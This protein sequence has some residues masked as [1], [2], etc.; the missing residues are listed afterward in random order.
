MKIKKFIALG[1]IHKTEKYLKLILPFIKD[2]KPDHFLLCGDTADFK[3]ISDYDRHER[4]VDGFAL[5]NKKVEKEIKWLNKLLDMF[6]KMLP[7]IIKDYMMGNH[8]ARY[9]KFSRYEQ[10]QLNEDDQ[11]LKNRLRLKERGWRHTE[12][13]GFVK[14]GKL[15]FM[16]GERFNGEN[17]AKS[18]AT[19]LRRNVRIFHHHTNQ[20]FSLTSPLQSK[21]TYEVK[22]VG[23]LCDTDPAYLRGLTNRWI[24]S[25]LVGYIFPNGDHQDFIVNIVNG[26]FIAPN[27]KVYGK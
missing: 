21:D 24:H 3:E 11:K 13:G 2:F 18:A 16:H 6:D 14:L 23:C 25:F 20:G 19:K 26:K 8:E 7:D 5:T 12:L 17:H 10:S 4:K 15:Y 9:D 1:D 22:S 27:G